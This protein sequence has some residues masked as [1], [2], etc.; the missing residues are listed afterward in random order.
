MEST[1]FNYVSEFSDFKTLVSKNITDSDPGKN[2]ICNDFLRDK[3]N[4]YVND[5]NSFNKCCANAETYLTDLIEGTSENVTSFC[6]FLNYWFYDKLKS[7]NNVT[8]SKDLLDKFFDEMQNVEDCNDSTEEIDE[9]TYS[10]LEK[11]V[12]LYENFYVFEEASSAE[13]HDRCGKGT[14]CAQ[15]YKNHESTCRGKGN[16]RL[17]NELENFRVLFNNHIKSKNKCQN[18]EELPSF[19]G[20]SLATTISLPVAYTPLGSWINPKLVKKKR[21]INELL[22]ES[23]NRENNTNMRQY[24]I[25]YN[26]S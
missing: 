9:P 25:A 2:G 7:I 24:N 10:D 21:P 22:H 23:G 13:D 14:K 15:D 18:M 3:L 20:P 8:Y 11:L 26:L 12:E 16:D 19:Q 17:C 6:K 4:G 5:D 1:I